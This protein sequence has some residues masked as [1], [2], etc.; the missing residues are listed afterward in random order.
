MFADWVVDDPER[1]WPDGR[2]SGRAVRSRKWRCGD[3]FGGRLELSMQ[4]CQQLTKCPRIPS[5][6]CRAGSAGKSW[7]QR[8]AATVIDDHG[9]AIRA[10]GAEQ[11]L[12]SPLRG[13]GS[14][15]CVRSRSSLMTAAG[16]IDAARG[17]HLRTSA[18]CSSLCGRA[19]SEADRCYMTHT[20]RQA[21]GSERASAHRA[22]KHWS[23]PCVLGGWLLS[24]RRP[25]GAG[26]KSDLADDLLHVNV[27]AVAQR[28]GTGLAADEQRRLRITGQRP[29]PRAD[30]T[31]ASVM[32]LQGTE[33]AAA[34][35]GLSH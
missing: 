15:P 16:C 27:G 23:G 11:Q 30:R 3:L 7:E 32:P 25:T 22:N 12:A 4:A 35:H 28:P 19:V 29:G 5:P 1:G 2:R 17:C 34:S 31:T 20:V 6:T 14:G 21:V 33:P 26:V 10:L 8:V 13:D 18:R 24:S 9:S